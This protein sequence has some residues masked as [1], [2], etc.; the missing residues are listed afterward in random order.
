MTSH[1]IGP[2][3]QNSVSIIKNEFTNEDEIWVKGT[4]PYLGFYNNEIKT[5][6]FVKNGWFSKFKKITQYLKKDLDFKVK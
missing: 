5:K 1:Y 6:K 3:G 2:F 4:Y